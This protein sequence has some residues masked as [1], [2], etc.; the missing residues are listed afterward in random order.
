[1]RGLT[2]RRKPSDNRII[3]RYDDFDMQFLKTGL[4]QD[5]KTSLDL[6][7]DMGKVF[8]DIFSTMS[9]SSKTR[10]KQW[11]A[12]DPR[13]PKSFKDASVTGDYLTLMAITQYTHL[14]EA[15]S[16]EARTEDQSRPLTS[17]I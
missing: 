13:C 16:D 8:C 7:K 12:S 11:S 17:I 1:M 10:V 2:R 5:L 3:K 14:D 15:V 6:K 9:K 4:E